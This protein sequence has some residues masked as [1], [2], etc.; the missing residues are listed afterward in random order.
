MGDL[1]IQHKGTDEMWADVNTNP[2]QGK[3]FSF[4]RGHVMGISEDYDD[5]VERRRTHPLFLLKIEYERLLAIDGEVLEKAAIVTPK[6]RPRKKTEPLPLCGIGI[7]I[8]PHLIR[9]LVLDIEIPYGN[10]ISDKKNLF[11]ICLLFFPVL[12][13]PFFA[14]IMVELLS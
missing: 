13:L 5:D 1:D 9:A 3:R 10:L 7:H 11:L 4:M 2:T 12:I 6:K 8:S 14:S